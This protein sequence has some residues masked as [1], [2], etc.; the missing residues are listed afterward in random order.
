M[1]KLLVESADMAWEV[2]CR[3]EDMR[4]RA[5]ENERRCIDDARRFVDEKGE[6]LKAVSHLSALIAGFAMIVMVEVQLPDKINFIL[7][8]TYGATSASVVGL[9]LLAMLNCTMMLIAVMKYDCIN[10]PIP[11]VEFWQTRCESDWRFAF[12]C[13]SAGVPLF[14][15][16]LAQIGWVVFAKY[17]DKDYRHNLNYRDLPASVVTAVAVL[18]LILWYLHTNAKWGGFVQH[19]SVKFVERN[20]KNAQAARG[21]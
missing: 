15:A 8:V 13:F 5:I 21:F 9:M 1:A 18:C 7:L 12:R 20:R 14:M 6:Q 19:S 4:Q 3:Q 10:R 16:V 11:F 17:E 2:K